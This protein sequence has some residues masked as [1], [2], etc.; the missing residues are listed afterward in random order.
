MWYDLRLRGV[1]V[2]RTTDRALDR[3]VSPSSSRGR[4][5]RTGP[6]T[7]IA[8]NGNINYVTGGVKLITT[9]RLRD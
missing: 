8:P 6:R 3:D 2:R 5:R 4:F 1:L 9:L 7:G